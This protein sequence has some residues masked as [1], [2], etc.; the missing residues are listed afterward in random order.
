MHQTD[1]WTQL[2][3]T[4]LCSFSLFI[5]LCGCVV[6]TPYC[7]STPFFLPQCWRITTLL[8]I[9]WRVLLWRKISVSNSLALENSSQ[10]IN[11]ELNH[12][13]LYNPSFPKPITAFSEISSDET[14]DLTLTIF[15]PDE[16]LE[17]TVDL[18]LNMQLTMKL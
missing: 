8:S 13:W 16:E 2:N 11:N 17:A 12:T 1:D 5:T 18:P 15:W 9:I 14:E 10:H 7:T 6:S 3:N 4:C